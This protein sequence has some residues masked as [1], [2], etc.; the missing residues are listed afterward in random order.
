MRSPLLVEKF[1]PVTIG[2]SGPLHLTNWGWRQVT[3]EARRR[4]KLPP[5]AG[6]SGQF[7]SFAEQAALNHLTGQ[8]NA[9][10]PSL[11]TQYLALCTAVPTSSSTGS[12]ITEATYTGYARLN[13]SGWAG[14]ASGV[15][16]ASSALLSA[17]AGP[18]SPTTPANDV[19]QAGQ[20]WSTGAAPWGS[21]LPAGTNSDYLSLT[22]CGFA[23]P[24]GATVLGVQVAVN[25]FADTV[26]A[27]SDLHVRLVKAGVV[28]GSDRALGGFWPTSGTVANYGSASDPWGTSLVGSDVNATNFGVA[29]AIQSSSGS[30]VTGIVNSVSI[31]VTYQ[32]NFAPCTGGTSTIVAVARCTALTVGNV[33]GWTDV[34]STVISTTQTPAVLAAYTASLT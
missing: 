31:T 12:T 20:G 10:W 34:P 1:E 7:S 18:R 9:A 32:L 11:N 6:G 21:V 13:V 17:P 26:N 19:S 8:D 23:I 4:G 16:P 28:T 3:K 30:A 15:A 5:M 25:R 24:A 14:P 2:P 27:V 33:L 29:L 22:G